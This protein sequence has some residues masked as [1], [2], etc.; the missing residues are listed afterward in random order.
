MNFLSCREP[1][2]DGRSPVHT[3]VKTYTHI[4]E[5]IQRGEIPEWGPNGTAKVPQVAKD[6]WRL[7]D[8]AQMI[9]LIRVVRADEAGH[10]FV[11]HSLAN[12]RRDDF[13]PVAMVH[14]SAKQQGQ[15]SGFTREESL[16]WARK[17]QEQMTGHKMLEAPSLKDDE[18]PKPAA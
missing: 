8:D 1:V 14:Q 17:V 9:D 6:F 3:A 15:M 12:L 4:I 13:N 7:P 18:K 11:N 10:R 16:E 2:A 5:A